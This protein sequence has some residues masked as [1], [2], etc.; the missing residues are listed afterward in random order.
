MG[1]SLQSKA[2]SGILWSA[3]ERFGQLGVSFLV[4]IVLA[5]LLAPE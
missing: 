1:I 4:Q 2:T 5:R 3:A